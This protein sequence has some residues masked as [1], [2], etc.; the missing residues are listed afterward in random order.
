MKQVR[1]V[2]TKILQVFIKQC[3][4]FL[5]CGDNVLGY[6]SNRVNN[7]WISKV[8]ESHTSALYKSIPVLYIDILVGG[9]PIQKGDHGKR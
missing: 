3:R 2:A 6:I 5:V 8:H 9:L 1:G 7:W 4:I